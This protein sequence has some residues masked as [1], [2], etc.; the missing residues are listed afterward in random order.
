MKSLIDLAALAH[1]SREVSYQIGGAP[2]E[3]VRARG[4]VLAVAVLQLEVQADVDRLAGTRVRSRVRG[5]PRRSDAAAG[6]PDASRSNRLGSGSIS[7]GVHRCP[8]LSIT[9][10]IDGRHRSTRSPPPP[11]GG[12]LRG[13][14]Q[15]RRIRSRGSVG[16][17][18]PRIRGDFRIRFM[19][20]LTLGLWSGTQ[21]GIYGDFGQIHQFGL[22][23]PRTWYPI[24][25]ARQTWSLT[26]VIADDRAEDG[27]DVCRAKNDPR[28][29]YRCD[30]EL[31]TFISRLVALEAEVVAAGYLGG[32]SSDRGPLSAD[33]VAGAKVVMVEMVLELVDPSHEGVPS[34]GLA[35]THLWC[36]IAA[37]IGN[38]CAGIAG[39]PAAIADTVTVAT[40]PAVSGP[41]VGAWSRPG[42]GCL[43]ARGGSRTCRRSDTSRMSSPLTAA[44]DQRRHPDVRECGERLTTWLG[45]EIMSRASSPGVGG[46]PS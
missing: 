46:G 14:A 28:G 41:C 27:A 42:W 38:A 19:W 7:S 25:I 9:I 45:D 4:T 6:A 22:A 39:L 43:Q 13:F 32:E 15:E 1:D 33:L 44:P 17:F 10:G 34:R 2:I 37:T 21:I 31:S 24:R 40:R 23:N 20:R 8:S 11:K 3:V 26:F 16:S 12:P 36:D 5:L 29:W 35:Q 30:W 18:G